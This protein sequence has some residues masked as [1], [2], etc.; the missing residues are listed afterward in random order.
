MTVAETIRLVQ[1]RIRPVACQED[2]SQAKEL[3]GFVLGIAPQSL[4]LHAGME[5]LP[6]QLMQLGEMVERRVGGEPLQYIFGEW[7]FMGLPFLVEKGILI[8][9]QDTEILCE[10][11]LKLCKA[12]GY[13]TALDICCGSGCIGITLAALGGLTVTSTDISA[14]CVR[15]TRENA[16]LNNVE[17]DVRT[18]DLFD[19]VFSESFDLIVCNP[20]YLNADDMK[21]LQREVAFEPR[22]ALYGGADGL[23]FYRRIAREYQPYLHAGGSL[24]L[25]IGSTQADAVCGLFSNASMIR[26]YGDNPRVVIVT[27]PQ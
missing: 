3:V 8:P 15:I 6:E 10:T 24:L 1:L 11:A 7:Q 2:L 12:N 21:S 18:G 5:V 25:E 22:L 13:K 14:D 26:D 16:A 19:A 27:L 17:L 20:P 23:D 4:M 9:R